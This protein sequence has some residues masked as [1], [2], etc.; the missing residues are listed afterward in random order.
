[1]EISIDAGSTRSR[2]MKKVAIPMSMVLV[3]MPSLAWAQ[4]PSGS[5]NYTWGPG[6]M[7]WGGGWS[8]MIFGFTVIYGGFTVTGFTVTVYLFRD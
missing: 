7:G 2:K 8:G 1:V 3:L 6:M 5:E 4:T